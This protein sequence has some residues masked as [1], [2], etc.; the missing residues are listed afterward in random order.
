MP[1]LWNEFKN[2]HL[3]QNMRA[4]YDPDFSKFLLRV[5]NGTEETVDANKIQIPNLMNIPFVNDDTSI[6]TLVSFVFPQIDHAATDPSVILNR[7]ILLTRNDFVHEI[8]HQMIQKFPGTE[9]VY[10]SYDE[11]LES[12]TDFQDQDLLDSLNQMG[13]P[14]MNSY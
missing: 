5:G 1:P 14:C 13:C 7:A 3:Q 9:R 2:I 6:N 4:K 12:S 10:F 11:V 8:N